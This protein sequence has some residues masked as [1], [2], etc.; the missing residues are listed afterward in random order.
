MLGHRQLESGHQMAIFVSSRINQFLL[1]VLYNS[2]NKQMTLD[3]QMNLCAFYLGNLG[4][5]KEK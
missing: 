4:Y 5:V 3:Q 1:Y 2:N